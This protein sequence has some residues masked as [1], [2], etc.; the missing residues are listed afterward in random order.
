MKI[1][2]FFVELGPWPPEVIT[3]TTLESAIVRAFCVIAFVKES[4]KPKNA[5]DIREQCSILSKN[6]LSLQVFVKGTTES[7]DDEIKK[8]IS[9]QT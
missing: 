6:C 9:P 8:L 4:G 3:A 5:I 1:L 7:H 2:S